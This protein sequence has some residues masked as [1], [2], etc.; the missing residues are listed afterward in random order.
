MW[1]WHKTCVR[2]FQIMNQTKSPIGTRGAGSPRNLFVI[3]AICIVLL[4]ALV[5]AVDLLSKRPD[6]AQPF[7]P[8]VILPQET[9]LPTS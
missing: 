7:P 9:P 2:G 6:N 4:I 5:V 8:P 1:P 3:L